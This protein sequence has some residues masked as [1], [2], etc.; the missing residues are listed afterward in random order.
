MRRVLAPLLL[1]A[2]AAC[3]GRVMKPEPTPRP[4]GT[5]PELGDDKGCGPFDATTLAACV[6][7]A[8]IEAD[9]AHI[10]VAR[11]PDSTAHEATRQLCADRF[12]A[13]GYEVELFPYP[14][15]VDVVAKKP[16]YTRAKDM[17]VAGAHYDSVPA[18][19]AADD[20]A[21]GVALLLEAARVLAGARLDRTLVVA[22]WDEGERRQLGSAAWATAAKARQDRI[23]LAVSF[24]A[25]GFF[26]DAPQTQRVPERFEELFPDQAL[27]LLDDQD[28]ANFLTVVADAPSRAAADAVVRHAAREGLK[29]HLLVLSSHVKAKQQDL[30]RSDHSSFWDAGFPA[31]LVTD[32]GP[33]R[34]GRIHCHDGADEPGSLDYRFAGR[35]ARAAVAALAETLVVR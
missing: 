27:A 21:S 23:T 18:C 7:P 35:V 17:V 1:L 28:R 12:H 29:T 3:G 5:V 11:P 26:S 4:H 22:C 16:G 30:H 34:N 24:E 10:A 9:I 33:F 25:V 14:S 19:A 32:T 6:D 31:M 8:A 15:G 2:S 13:L 20:N